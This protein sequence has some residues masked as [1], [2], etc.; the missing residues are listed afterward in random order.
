MLK[1][2]FGL[3]FV[4]VRLIDPMILKLYLLT[5]EKRIKIE[6]KIAV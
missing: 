6:I 2:P 1:K 3:T 4:R 5:I